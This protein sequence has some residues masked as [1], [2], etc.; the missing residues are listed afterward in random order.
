MLRHRHYT[1]LAGDDARLI[2]DEMFRDEAQP[3]RPCLPNMRRDKARR[4]KIFQMQ[5][6]RQCVS[7][8]GGAYYY[9]FSLISRHS[10]FQFDDDDDFDD[11]AMMFSWI[12]CTRVIYAED[13]QPTF[14]QRRQQRAAVVALVYVM[15]PNDRCD[16]GRYSLTRW[17][18]R[19]WR[20]KA[21]N[22][23]LII[24]LS[25]LQSA[26]N[27]W[28]D[29]PDECRLPEHWLK[30]FN[31]FS[32]GARIS[33]HAM[34][35]FFPAEEL[36]SRLPRFTLHFSRVLVSAASRGQDVSV[37]PPFSRNNIEF[38]IRI[39]I[40]IMIS[41]NG[42][43]V[44]SRMVPKRRDDIAEY[45]WS[46]FII[47]ISAYVVFMIRRYWHYYSAEGRTPMPPMRLSHLLSYL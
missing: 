43:G 8:P 19:W 1:T 33:R 22:A 23:C 37:M 45:H 41:K 15:P 14:Y 18:E 25:A 47:Y 5:Q 32:Q 29:S 16:K 17:Q 35:V 2:S 42:Q 21:R 31:Y 34:A 46:P 11:D 9:S 27:S 3:A 24:W 4:Q 40:W 44:L 7:L 38:S 10:I 13:F 39:S 6:P 20:Q 36:F 26:R 28:G 30:C 12:L